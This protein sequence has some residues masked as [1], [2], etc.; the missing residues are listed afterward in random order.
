MIIKSEYV[1]MKSIIENSCMMASAPLPAD[2]AP[3]R[4][5][6]R[7][8]ASLLVKIFGDS[9]NMNGKCN[10][11]GIANVPALS[12][13]AAVARLSKGEEEEVRLER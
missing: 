10:V 3:A 1:K 11:L 2:S 5:L 4:P 6:P 7:G 8:L 13:M 12:E 9:G